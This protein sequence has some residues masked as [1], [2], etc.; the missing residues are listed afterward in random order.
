M[1][2]NHKSAEWKRVGVLQADALTSRAIKR[3]RH[4]LARYGQIHRRWRPVGSDRAR[5]VRRYGVEH[6][7]YTAR[8]SFRIDNDRVGAVGWQ[9]DGSCCIHEGLVTRRN[10]NHAQNR[11]GR[12][13]G[14]RYWL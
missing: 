3:I 7:N 14:L 12:A 2:F 11:R 6:Q 9:S 10:W 4:V 1:F 8:V 13:A 5:Y